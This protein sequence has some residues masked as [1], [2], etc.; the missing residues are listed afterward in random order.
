M[1]YFRSL[2][3]APLSSHTT[4]RPDGTDTSFGSQT[5]SRQTVREPARRIPQTLRAGRNALVDYQLDGSVVTAHLAARARTT[6]SPLLPRRAYAV[7]GPSRRVSPNIPLSAPSARHRSAVISMAHNSR[8]R[9][10]PIAGRRAA[11]NAEPEA[12]TQATTMRADRARVGDRSGLLVLVPDC[13]A[14]TYYRRRQASPSQSSHW[15]WTGDMYWAQQSARSSRRHA[16]RRIG[17]ASCR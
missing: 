7:A 16:E 15:R 10:R 11:Q 6:A 2:A 5:H 17:T 12:Q 9:G 13:D 3:L 8:E 1:S 4:A 14:G